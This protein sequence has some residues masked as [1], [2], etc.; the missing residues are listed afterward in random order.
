MRVE[1]VE[2]I[3]DVRVAVAKQRVFAGK[4]KVAVGGSATQFALGSDPSLL[5]VVPDALAPPRP[6]QAI[7]EEKF[8]SHRQRPSPT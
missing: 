1:G 7:G 3:R 2:K 6:W 8:Q 4:N 5:Q